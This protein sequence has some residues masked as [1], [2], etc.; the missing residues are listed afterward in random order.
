[1][2]LINVFSFRR[3]SQ[4]K[5]FILLKNKDKIPEKEKIKPQKKKIKFLKKK[6]FL[7]NN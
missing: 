5:P 4:F 6:D 7:G 3:L 2:K 1:M